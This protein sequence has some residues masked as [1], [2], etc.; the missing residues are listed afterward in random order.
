[1]YARGPGKCDGSARGIPHRANSAL[2]TQDIA[3]CTRGALHFVLSAHCAP[4]ALFL[5]CG[6]DDGESFL[7]HPPVQTAQFRPKATAPQCRTTFPPPCPSYGLVQATAGVGTVLVLVLVSVCPQS[8]G[9][10][11]ICALSSPFL[12]QLMCAGSCMC[13]AKA[14]ALS[15]LQR[16]YGPC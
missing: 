9:F 16:A 3:H 7:C 14:T 11:Y 10:G 4:C 5:P 12:H 2:G 15:K 1:M 13:R 6:P 8:S